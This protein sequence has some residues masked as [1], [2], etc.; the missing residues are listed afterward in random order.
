MYRRIG[1]FMSRWMSSVRSDSDVS[2]VGVE[3]RIAEAFI[4]GYGIYD[5]ASAQME[6]SGLIGRAQLAIRLITL[7]ESAL[8]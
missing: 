7:N 4:L 3:Y 8:M 2:L 6:Y 1:S 5:R